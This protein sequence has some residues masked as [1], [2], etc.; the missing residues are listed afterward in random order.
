MRVTIASVVCLGLVLSRADIASAADGGGRV[1]PAS[2]CGEPSRIATVAPPGEPL[3][4]ESQGDEGVLWCASPDDPR[5]SPLDSGASGSSL[6]QAKLGCTGCNLPAHP[7][8][9]E[10]AAMSC[11]GQYSGSARE[12]VLARL[13]RPPR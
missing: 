2:V 7:V 1:V 8:L 5:C 4:G 13:E 10:P 6:A 9:R 3:G 11:G 12:G